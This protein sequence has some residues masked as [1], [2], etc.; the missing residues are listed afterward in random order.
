[1]AISQNVLFT[2]AENPPTD[3]GSPG[4]AVLTQV[5][6]R[7]LEESGWAVK[8][9]DTWR[10]SGRRLTALREEATLEVSLAEIE[11]QKWLLQV[12]PLKSPGIL[13]RALG[14]T[15][16]AGHRDCLEI[17]QVVHQAL[18]T[19]GFREMRWCW[20]DY[21]DEPGSTKEPVPF[22]G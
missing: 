19:H 12:T 11:E 1:M 17:A 16:S 20:N 15:D 9:V 2:G 3:E 10:D 4:G 8:D 14:R 5:L 6:Q 7:A 22:G 18:T 21:P 13:G